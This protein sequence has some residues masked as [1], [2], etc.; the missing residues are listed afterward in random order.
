MIKFMGNYF[1]TFSSS[2]YMLKI[3]RIGTELVVASRIIY[4]QT[5]YVNFD[6]ILLRS[7]ARNKFFAGSIFSGLF[8][9]RNVRTKGL[10]VL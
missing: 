4:P 2:F 9:P 1:E 10:K 6:I 7:M 8:R 5:V 3:S